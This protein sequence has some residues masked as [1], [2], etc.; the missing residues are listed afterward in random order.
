MLFGASALAIII[1]WLISFLNGTTYHMPLVFGLGRIVVILLSVLVDMGMTNFFLKASADPMQAKVSD[2]WHP[3]PYMSYLGATL[4]V[5]ILTVI[6]FFLLIVP[7]VILMLMWLF[8]KFLIIDKNLGPIEAMK[9]S[10]RMT[11]GHRLE[12]LLLMMFVLAVNIIGLALLFIGL[13]VTVPLTLLIL[14]DA[15]RTIEKAAPA[16]AAT[17]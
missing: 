14:V 7:G 15:Y 17:A 16:P 2:L 9:V 5:G 1:L 12:L 3:E 8:V 11:K 6:G 4:L 13:F 10:A